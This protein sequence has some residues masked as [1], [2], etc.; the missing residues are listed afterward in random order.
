LKS[1]Y[2]CT[3]PGLYRSVFLHA[4]DEEDLTKL[5]VS[6]FLN[7]SSYHLGFVREQST[8]ETLGLESSFGLE[9]KLLTMAK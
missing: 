7:E 3:A 9:Y 1:F 8:S 4:P 2:R 5:G 6:Y